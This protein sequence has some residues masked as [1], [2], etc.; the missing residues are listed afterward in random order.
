MDKN[1]VGNVAWFDLTVDHVE[2]V[3]AFYK[4]VVGWQDN[5]INMGV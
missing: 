5:P 4:S 1:E 3:K 2:S